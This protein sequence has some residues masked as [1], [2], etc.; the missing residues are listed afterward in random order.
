M[1]KSVLI[2]FFLFA[3]GTMLSFAQTVTLST[4]GVAPYDV[5]VDTVEHYFDRPY[6]S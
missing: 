5:T 2:F 6:N 1:K 3:V 4:Y